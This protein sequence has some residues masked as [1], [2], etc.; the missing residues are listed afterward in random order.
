M[1]LYWL[2]IFMPRKTDTPKEKKDR[3]VVSVHARARKERRE[4]M[5][6][7]QRG[8]GAIILFR[9]TDRSRSTTK[10]NDQPHR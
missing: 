10:D 8:V 6:E 4:V 9:L 5:R 3:R 7:P 2:V 1:E